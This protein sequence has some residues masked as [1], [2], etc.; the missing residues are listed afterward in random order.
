MRAAFAV[1]FNKS[2]A[3]NTHFQLLEKEH[4]F[5]GLGLPAWSMILYRWSAPD[6]PPFNKST[7]KFVI[8][9]VI[10]MK[11]GA[12]IPVTLSPS[13]YKQGRSLCR[14]IAERL[15][16]PSAGHVSRMIWAHMGEMTYQELAK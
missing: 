14:E 13:G 5:S 2:Q 7:K 11:L 6:Y 16:L 15:R 1:A 12:S 10:D 3:V 8:E 4:K 9:F